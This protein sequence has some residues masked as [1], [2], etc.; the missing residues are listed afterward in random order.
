MQ[1]NA[2]GFAFGGA[3]WL[4]VLVE[5]TPAAGHAD[6]ATDEALKQI[7]ETANQ[8]CQSA[9]LE[10]TSQ[11]VALSGDAQAKVGGLVGRIADLGISGAAKYQ[12]GHSMG[13]LQQDLKDAIQIGDSCKLEVFKTLE[14]DLIRGRNSGT[15]GSLNGGLTPPATSSTEAQPIPVQPVSAPSWCP[16]A[17]T[18][19]ERLICRTERL[20]AL[21][22]QLTDAYHDAMSRM[23]PA[24][25]QNLK[26]DQNY[27]IQQRDSCQWN[28]DVVSCVERAYST[29]L[30]V[31]GTY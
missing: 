29:R 17:S 14:K 7:I 2:A 20:A 22:A 24:Q 26:R 28:S 11:G 31:L 18:Q 19:V 4:A 27:W 3:L 13:V 25:Q 6:G 1:I 21:D 15:S 23:P 9:P 16:R 30:A 12:T 8:I 10:Q 5:L